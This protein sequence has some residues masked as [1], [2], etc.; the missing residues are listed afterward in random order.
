MIGSNAVTWPAD[1][2][3]LGQLIWAGWPRMVILKYAGFWWV[4]GSGLD[5]WS[6]LSVISHQEG[7]K[8][9][10]L[11]LVFEG[12]PE[13]MMGKFQSRGSPTSPEITFTNVILEEFNHICRSKFKGW[14]SKID[15]VLPTFW[16]SGTTSGEQTMGWRP[17]KKTT[18]WWG[19]QQRMWGIFFKCTSAFSMYLRITGF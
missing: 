10:L 1:F 19:G 3:S 5:G 14:R 17:L 7:G 11:H 12:S 8:L 2:L 18:S 9:E 16:T 4:Y 15:Q 6:G 13:L